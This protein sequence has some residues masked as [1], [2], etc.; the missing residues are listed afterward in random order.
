MFSPPHQPFHWYFL[1]KTYLDETS[2]DV[3]IVQKLGKDEELLAQKLISKVHSRVHD[4]RTVCTDRVGNMADV[5]GV[6]MFVV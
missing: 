2:F 3:F 6:Q 1:F 5:N 4:S